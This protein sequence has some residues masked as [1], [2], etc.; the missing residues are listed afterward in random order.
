MRASHQAMKYAATAL[1]ICLIVGAAG[2]LMRA[3]SFFVPF[4]FSYTTREYT[5]HDVTDDIR[6]LEINLKGVDLEVKRAADGV[7]RWESNYRYLS[8]TEEGNRLLLLDRRNFHTKNRYGDA[9]LRVHIP[10]GM[11]FDAVDISSGAGRMLLDSIEAESLQLQLGAGKATLQNIRA[12]GRADIDAGVGDLLIRDSSFHNL[13]LDMGVGQ[14]DFFGL[15]EG[16]T[17]LLL[18]VGS[19]RF[20][21][22][23]SLSDYRLEIKQGL[24]AFLVDGEPVGGDSELGEGDREVQIEAGLGSVRVDFSGE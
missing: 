24:G 17:R 3:V 23:G 12:A 4:F 11:V 10:A 22:V 18:G 14:L 8:V 7:F 2:L 6:V 19:S 9:L 1:A 20:D 16:R 15:L 5:S 21:L 13:D